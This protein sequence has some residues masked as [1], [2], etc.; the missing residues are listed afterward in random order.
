MLRIVLL[1][2]ILGFNLIALPVYAESVATKKLTSSDKSS[3]SD[4]KSVI[5]VSSKEEE[6]LRAEITNLKEQQQVLI[7]YSRQLRSRYK[8]LQDHCFR[9]S[10]KEPEDFCQP[11]EDMIQISDYKT[12]ED[13]FHELENRYAVVRSDYDRLRDN[14]EDT[15]ESLKA[16]LAKKEEEINRYR[17][18]LEETRRTVSSFPTMEKELLS[19]KNE[20]MLFKSAEEILKNGTASS[21]A[22]KGTEYAAARQQ[23]RPA[24]IQA[25]PVIPSD[26]TI[27]EVTGSK[28][29]LRA[30]PGTEH[31]SIMDVQKG[32]KLTMEAKE[33]DWYRVFS[34]TGGRAFIHSQY[35]KVVSQRVPSDYSKRAQMAAEPVRPPLP[36]KPVRRVGEPASDNSD[37]SQQVGVEIT[38]N[39]TEA[40]AIEKL[41]KAMGG[42]L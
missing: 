8:D 4:K 38:E 26:V 36:S 14:N 30:G 27:V 39:D 18:E 40:L 29:S 15:V 24:E 34:P 37:T 1:Y 7:D 28:V 22:S 11:P 33:K 20:L 31:S 16:S 10:K 23:N 19:L 32:T 21:L 5:Y 42:G 6:A 13:Q 41:M 12:L 25:G 3:S 17:K 9:N 35:A 2:F